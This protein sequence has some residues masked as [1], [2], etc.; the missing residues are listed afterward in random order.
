MPASRNV[1]RPGN[2]TERCGDVTASSRSFPGPA[3]GAT[4][5]LPAD[6]EDYVLPSAN[7]KKSVLQ[8][9]TANRQN[10]APVTPPTRKVRPMIGNA[11]NK[12]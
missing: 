12:L 2:S 3:C 10:C 7:D 4:D 9:T 8:R 11:A 5:P 1:G 6:L